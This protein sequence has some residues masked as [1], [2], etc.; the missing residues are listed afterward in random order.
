MPSSATTATASPR[1]PRTRCDTAK[2]KAWALEVAGRRSRDLSTNIDHQLRAELAAGLR[3]CFSDLPLPQRA[4][5]G[6]LHN[7]IPLPPTA[8]V[9]VLPKG[10]SIAGRVG[11]V[12]STSLGTAATDFQV[13]P[14]T[15]RLSMEDRGRCSIDDQLNICLRG[16]AL[17]LKEIIELG[18]P[19]LEAYKRSL[20]FFRADE[21]EVVKLRQLELD[22]AKARCKSKVRFID[23]LTTGEQLTS[24]LFLEATYGTKAFYANDGGYKVVESSTGPSIIG[25]CASRRHCGSTMGGPM[26]VEQLVGHSYQ[27]EAAALLS[28]LENETETR[29]VITFDATSPVLAL[30]RFASCHDRRRAQYFLDDWLSALLKALGRFEL[31]VFAWTPAHVGI[32]VNEWVDA[33]AT[34]FMEGAG[35][36]DFI[37]LPARTHSSLSFQTSSSAFKHG[38]RAFTDIAHNHL[39]RPRRTPHCPR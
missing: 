23:P 18:S 13:S 37:A 1:S 7:A 31:V 25:S 28:T 20:D 39:L 2:L 17:G 38:V 10:K 9:A 36:E 26:V 4:P 27:T 22:E 30:L 24:H 3:T 6:A 16:A 29:I 8:I 19:T 5:A 21:V 14:C 12:V 15:L 34:E 11:A 35:V 32:S 33:L